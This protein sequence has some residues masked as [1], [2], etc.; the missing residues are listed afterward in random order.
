VVEL[1]VRVA[2]CGE[3]EHRAAQSSFPGGLVERDVPEHEPGEH[4][5]QLARA[6]VEPR[7]VKLL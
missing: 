7:G 2:A 5:E 3:D 1:A 6:R 4:D